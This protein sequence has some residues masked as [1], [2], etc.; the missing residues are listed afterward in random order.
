MAKELDPQDLKSAVNFL[1][2]VG[3]LAQTPR[4][5]FYFLGS[6]RQSTAEHLNR[7][8][9]I[10]FVLAFMEGNVD[11]EKILKMCLFHD[12]AEVRTSDL[13]Y[14]HQKYVERHEDK[15]VQDL[16]SI[17][18]FGADILAIITEYEE[19]KTPESII[20]KDADN[21]EWILSLKEQVD[22]GNARAESWLPSAIKR[23][24]TKSAK[25]LAEGIMQTN[26]DEWWFD[27]DSPW[28][29]DR[30]K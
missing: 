1:Y 3:M 26:S 5:G 15:A 14:V 23:L 17:V 11:T 19:R 18:P 16:T 12:L 21:L 24:K 28:W 30:N 25:K 22:I 10:G 9:Y 27:R 29:V 6:G 4:S 2:E 20:V 13:N 7:V 8:T